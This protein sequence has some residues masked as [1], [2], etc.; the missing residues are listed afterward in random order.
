MMPDVPDAMI[1]GVDDI[2]FH[3][4]AIEN[5]AA[6]LQQLFPDTRGVVGFGLTAPRAK[7]YG[8]ALVGKAFL[9]LY[10]A[11]HLFFPGYFHFGAQEIGTHA[12]RRSEFFLCKDAKAEHYHPADPP[13]GI[14]V[15]VDQTHHDARRWHREDVMIGQRRHTRG[16]VWGESSRNHEYFDFEPWLREWL[17][18]VR[19]SRILEWGP[20][21]STE[22]MNEDMPEAYIMSI[23]HVAR[24]YDRAKKLYGQFAD[25]RFENVPFKGESN[26]AYLP[27]KE[28]ADPFDLIFVDGAMR[29]ECLAAAHQLIAPRGVVIVHDAERESYSPGMQLFDEIETSADGH[30]K[31]LRPKTA[32]PVI[33]TKPKPPAPPVKQL[34]EQQ[35]VL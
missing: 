24:W 35:E 13:P 8:L 17:K 6:K 30:T 25:V 23:E 11:R 15:P 26:Y 31:V 21:Y 5:A 9:D 16:I 10:P 12:M 28:N 7:P 1:Y 33:V 2:E 22:L 27:I 32:Q 14:D 3:P 4:N 18:Q 20:G 34:P 29:V 19:P